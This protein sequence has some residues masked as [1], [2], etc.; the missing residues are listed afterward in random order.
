MS[1]SAGRAEV[2]GKASF[3]APGSEPEEAPGPT[4][5][6]PPPEGCGAER[7]VPLGRTQSGSRAGEDL[8]GASS[9]AVSLASPLRGA[10]IYLTFWP[11]NLRG[12]YFFKLV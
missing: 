9:R 3:C 6:P 4:Q 10:V 2:A 11:E 8:A 1:H 5:P 12:R 7:S